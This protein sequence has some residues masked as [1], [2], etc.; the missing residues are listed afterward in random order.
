MRSV[1]CLLLALC[2]AGSH[3]QGVDPK[4]VF[5]AVGLRV[6]FQVRA[7]ADAT[8]CLGVLTIAT[9]IHAVMQRMTAGAS[10]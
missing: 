7:N 10:A 1:V 5:N 3:S 4:Q 9:A 6:E 8:L 2:L